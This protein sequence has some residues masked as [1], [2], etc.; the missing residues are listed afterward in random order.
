MGVLDGKHALVCGASAG[1]GRAC[2]TAFAAEGA[3]VTLLARRA[4]VLETALRALPSPLP[5]VP[6]R[7]IAADLDDL[8]TTADIVR[9]HVAAH[10]PV[11]VLVNNA[12]GPPGGPIVDASA[13]HFLAAFRR[14]MLGAHLLSQIVL[15]GM[16]EARYGRIV[17]VISTSVRQPIAGLGVS[18]TVRGACASWAKTLAREVAPFGVTVNNVLPGA[19]RTER[20]ASI[21]EA[22]ARARGVAPDVIEAELLREIPAGRFGEPEDVAAAALFLASPAASYVSGVSIP[23][24]GARLEAL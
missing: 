19:T 18:N 9:R 24:D 20:L 14:L 15:P 12:A 23:V 6:H 2:A 10:G 7:A 3:T 1:I 5:G 21:I 16:R 4:E 22:R 13:E 11:H 17:N 8:E